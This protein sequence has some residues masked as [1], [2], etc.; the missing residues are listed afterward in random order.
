M[1]EPG[2]ANAPYAVGVLV[3]PDPA[4]YL[5]E[6]FCSGALIAPDLVLTAGHCAAGFEAA[7]LSVAVGSEHI[8]DAVAYPVVGVLVHPGY[9][10]GEGFVLNPLAND[11][12]L[13]RLGE[14]VTGVAPIKLAPVND[15]P[16]RGQRSQ[17]RVFGWGIDETGTSSG[18]LGRAPK[19]DVTNKRSSP[20][21]GL[22]KN[23]QLLARPK[24][25]SNPCVGDSGGPLVGNRPG[26]NVP[27]L[28][29]LVSYGSDVC[30]TT[31]PVVYTRIAGYRPWIAEAIRTLRN[32]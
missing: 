10:P 2:A 23:L 4:T 12:A 5:P 26:K 1:N 25:R 17:L 7:S 16:V 9:E 30:G 22:D 21:A 8:L 29:G 32:R 3:N 20:Y 19:V 24:G 18:W 11:I 27:F 28:V 6:L 13:L 31:M 15:A 14:P